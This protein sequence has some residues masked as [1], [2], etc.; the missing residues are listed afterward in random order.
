MNISVVLRRLGSSCL[1][2][3]GIDGS[4]EGRGGVRKRLLKDFP[5][6]SDGKASACSVGDPGLIPGS[7]RCPGEGNGYPLYLFLPGESHGQR[8]LAGYHA[9]GCQESDMA[10]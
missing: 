3:V 8:S 10:Q 9:W 2:M 5:S 7:G 4:R 6:G 1:T